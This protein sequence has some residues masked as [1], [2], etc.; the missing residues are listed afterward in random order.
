MVP[1]GPR[2]TRRRRLVAMSDGDRDGDGLVGLADRDGD[3]GERV[4]G[5]VEPG[6]LGGGG[7]GAVG[8]AE[9]VQPVV[10][11]AAV[12]PGEPTTG[13]SLERVEDLVGAT[14]QVG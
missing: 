2:T 4:L 12:L 1:A 14:L 3:Q 8:P 6:A 9:L 5:Q 10:A 11:V 13:R 7:V